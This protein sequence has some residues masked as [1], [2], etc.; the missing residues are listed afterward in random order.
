VEPA[1]R[2]ALCTSCAALDRSSS[3]A[4]DNHLDDP[5]TFAVYL[6]HHGSTIKVG[7]TATERGTSRLLEQ[8]ALA[9]VILSVG[10]LASARRTEHLLAVALGMPDRVT[11]AAKRTARACPGILDAHAADLMVAARQAEQ[12]PWPEGQTRCELQVS[13]HTAEYGLPGGGLRPAAEV[14]PL[15]PQC[16]VGGTVTCRIGSDVYL[17]SAPGLVL[18]DTRLLAGWAIGRADPRAPFT[19]PLQPLKPLQVGHDVLF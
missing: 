5:R 9:S 10:S 15:T 17:D 3:I 19:A 8:G 1:A 12:L 16:T 7:I 13:D 6:A 18:L 4:A 2:S 11:T 14:L